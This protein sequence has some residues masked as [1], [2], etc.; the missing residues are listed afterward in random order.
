MIGWLAILVL[1]ICLSSV[2]FYCQVTM[3]CSQYFKL[4][5]DKSC[6][7]IFLI[8]N[9]ITPYVVLSDGRWLKMYNNRRCLDTMVL[10]SLRVVYK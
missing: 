8:I 2:V 7:L 1:F 4:V 5:I 10:N 3:S 9:D 6:G